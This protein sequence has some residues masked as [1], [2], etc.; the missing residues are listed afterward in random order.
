MAT[1]QSIISRAQTALFD[2]SGVRWPAAELVGHL[3]DAQRALVTAR[4]DLKSTLQPLALAAGWRQQVPAQAL[5]L[6][7]IPSNSTG[8]RKRITKTSQELLE[9][10]APEWRSVAQSAEITH[11]MFDPLTEPRVFLVYPPASASA[12]VDILYAT[13]PVDVPTPSGPTAASVTG[14]IDLRDEWAEPLF[15]YVMFKAYSKDAEFGGNANL[16]A[17]YMQLFSGAANT[18]ATAA[19]TAAPRK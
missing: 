3:N 19:A 7:G 14:D 2:P 4:P 9:A 6:M 5:V 10:V 18:Q 11:F 17:S 1:A 13:Y 15:N 8:K 12:Q 16:A